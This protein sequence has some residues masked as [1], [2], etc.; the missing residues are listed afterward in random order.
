M[1]LDRITERKARRILARAGKILMKAGHVYV[2]KVF[3]LKDSLKAAGK[4]FVTSPAD[5]DSLDEPCGFEPRTVD[6]KTEMVK[7]VPTLDMNRENARYYYN[8]GSALYRYTKGRED[9]DDGL[10]GI[11]ETELIRSA[12]R[13]I[14]EEGACEY[15]TM[16]DLAEQ[17]SII[18]ERT[19]QCCRECPEKLTQID[20]G[21]RKA[22][23]GRRP[24]QSGPG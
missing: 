16:V 6:G 21:I 20:L 9:P 13:Q 22:L 7:S 11:D 19:L 2:D 24:R 5:P 17:L 14:A 12:F 3:L 4:A 1:D 10:G 18:R 8:L 23:T 15:S